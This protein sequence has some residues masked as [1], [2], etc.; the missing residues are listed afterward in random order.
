MR[1]PERETID[2]WK[3]NP[4]TH[5]WFGRMQEDA[6]TMLGREGLQP[7]VDIS[8]PGRTAMSAAF[9]KGVR[10][11]IAWAVNYEAEEK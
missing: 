2:E 9:V 11:G 3:A 8:D 6:E 10:E 1:M 4:V 5:W 7:I